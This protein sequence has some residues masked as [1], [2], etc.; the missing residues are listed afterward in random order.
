MHHKRENYI[1]VIKSICR[2]TK[3]KVPERLDHYSDYN[4]LLFLNK[5][6]IKNNCEGL[7]E[8]DLELELY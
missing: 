4:L 8:P 5:L 3:S 2:E 6:L 1:T 7:N